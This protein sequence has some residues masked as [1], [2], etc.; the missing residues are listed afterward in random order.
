[1]G[2][3]GPGACRPCPCRRRA[4]ST[5]RTVAAS[6][7]S[8]VL[9]GNGNSVRRSPTLQP[10][11]T[12]PTQF[13][14]RAHETTATIAYGVARSGRLCSPFRRASLTARTNFARS[15]SCPS[16]RT[17]RK[18]SRTGSASTCGSKATVRPSA[19]R[20]PGTRVRP[21]APR[22]LWTRQRRCQV[23]LLDDDRPVP[24]GVIGEICVRLRRRHAMFEGTGGS[25]TKRF[26]RSVACGT[27]PATA[28]CST[29]TARCSSSTARKA[30]LW[31]R[32]ENVSSLE[33]EA[34]ITR[35]PNILESAV[36]AVPSD[37]TEDDSKACIYVE[38][39]DS[40]PKN[41]VGRV[42]KYQTRDRVNSNDVW[43]LD[44]LGLTVPRA[45][46]R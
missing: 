15:C 12:S 20:S 18:S 43:D 13:F 27:T 31:R 45:E 23:A 3:R 11:L 41:A 1:M 37:A 25:S 35:H 33:L 5:D 8:A 46:R 16:R 42:M 39:V 28:A 32:G 38:F 44:A 10:F 24:A 26:E 17:R 19:S 6:Y 40:M 30:A 7:R 36:L 22:L 2:A 34:A 14:R 21:E 29:T 4:V 9:W